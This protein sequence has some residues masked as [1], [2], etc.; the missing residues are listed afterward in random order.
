MLDYSIK[1]IS[2]IDENDLY[3][4][5]KI[6]FKD[7]YKIL[8]TYY[9]WWYRIENTSC[10]PILI[11]LKDKIVGQL[12]TLPT[13]IN[14]KQELFSGSWFVDFAVL[15]EFQGKGVGSILVNEASKL[16][17]IQL[18]FCNEAALK[19]YR[20]LRWN[21]NNETRRIIRPIN[22]IKWLPVVKSMKTRFFS[23]FYN[24][25]LSKV[26]QTKDSIKPLDLE[27]N[28]KQLSENFLKRKIQNSNT[29]FELSRNKEWFDWRFYEFPFK[30]N[31]KFFEYKGNY[32]IVHEIITGNIKRLHLIFHFY[33]D[34]SL[35][36]ELYRLITKW[37]IENDYDLVWSCS[38]NY[39]LINNLKDVMPSMFFKKIIIASHSSNQNI[40]KN[41]DS[42][43]KNIQPSD[44]DMDLVFLK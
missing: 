43:F 13:K 10:E 38:A 14:F 19:V 1:K 22:P 41:L 35:E 39:S 7:R 40:F 18:A 31:L 30:K 15:P 26:L 2:E 12:A 8:T 4:F 6:T 17:D 44:S 28:F 20:K 33:L 37:A 27:I 5:Y 3:N 21:I 42:G 24:S 16:S 9:K 36:E 23:N 25:S 34:L 29:L 32:V 11:T